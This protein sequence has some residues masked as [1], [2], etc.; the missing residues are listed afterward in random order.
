MVDATQMSSESISIGMYDFHVPN[1]FLFCFWSFFVLLLC[2]FVFSHHKS[3]HVSTAYTLGVNLFSYKFNIFNLDN[4]YII[5]NH[6]L[7]TEN[8]NTEPYI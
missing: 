2:I 1:M 4:I 8:Y 6:F 3:L 7:K 5:D